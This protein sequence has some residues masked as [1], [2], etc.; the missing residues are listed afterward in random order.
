MT[1]VSLALQAPCGAGASWFN[2][3]ILIAI[4]TILIIEEDCFNENCITITNCGAG[5][6]TLTVQCLFLF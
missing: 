6:K 1:L 5:F 4:E 2:F 3:Y